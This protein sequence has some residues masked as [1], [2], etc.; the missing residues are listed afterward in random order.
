LYTKDILAA[1]VRNNRGSHDCDDPYYAHRVTENYD[2]RNN[3]TLTKEKTTT[4]ATPPIP[5]IASDSILKQKPFQ[6]N[7]NCLITFSELLWEIVVMLSKQG[8]NQL[9]HL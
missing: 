2:N 5:V 9:L 7:F 4:T 3:S 6:S 8:I 1:G